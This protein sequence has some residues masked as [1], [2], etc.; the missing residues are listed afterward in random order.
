[1][2]FTVRGKAICSARTDA[3]G[4]AACR[5]SGLTEARIVLSGSFTA[6]FTGDVDYTGSSATT[7]W[8]AVG[9]WTSWR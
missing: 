9:S 7:R 6:T 4:R 2:T 8:L 1:V 3:N 5:I